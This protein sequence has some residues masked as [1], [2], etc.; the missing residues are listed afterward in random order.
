MIFGRDHDSWAC[1]STHFSWSA[2]CDIPLEVPSRAAPDPER[3]S[4][5]WVTSKGHGY[6][7]R[8]PAAAESKPGIRGRFS[9]GSSDDDSSGGFAT[10]LLRDSLLA[11]WSPSR[12]PNGGVGGFRMVFLCGHAFPSA[13]AEASKADCSL[14]NRKHF[15]GCVPT[16]PVAACS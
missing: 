9:D 15:E 1:R 6:V 10:A 2:T 11:G 3:N 8:G 5:T 16:W 13:E 7:T 4:S 12:Q 14:G